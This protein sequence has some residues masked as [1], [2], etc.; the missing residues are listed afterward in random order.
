VIMTIRAHTE[1][2]GRCRSC[3]RPIVWAILAD[4]NRHPFD[5]PLSIVDEQSN[6]FD[7]G[8][9]VVYIDTRKSPSHFATC[10]NAHHHRTRGNR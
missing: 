8:G 10:P 7:A 3:R 5:G 6:L 4:G 9:A 1:Q 2:P